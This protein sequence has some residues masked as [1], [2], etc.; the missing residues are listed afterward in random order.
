[1]P[2]STTKTIHDD[3]IS[4]FSAQQISHDLFSS[5]TQKDKTLFCTSVGVI[6]TSETCEETFA[7]LTFVWFDF[8]CTH[9]QKT[10]SS[11]KKYSALAFWLTLHISFSLPD[12]IQMSE[13]DCGIG[14]NSKCTFATLIKHKVIIV[15]WANS[16]HFVSFCFSS[17]VV[18]SFAD[19][20]ESYEVW[21]IRKIVHHSVWAFRRRRTG[22]R[23]E[24]LIEFECDQATFRLKFS[25][26]WVTTNDGSCECDDC[27][28]TN[29]LQWL[30]RSE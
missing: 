6:F 24:C 7:S 13:I 4:C 8:S 19:T 2:I 27:E 15:F 22:T 21:L 14:G 12:R 11:K 3:T 17:S 30:D 20:K 23:A 10:I 28:Q 25:C 16:L 9:M 5:T 29:A 18:C 1:M 26:L